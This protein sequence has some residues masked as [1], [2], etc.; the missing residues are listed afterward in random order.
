MRLSP[1]GTYQLEVG[2]RKS[3]MSLQIYLTLA[4]ARGLVCFILYL[5]ILLK[6]SPVNN[7]QKHMNIYDNYNFMYIILGG[8]NPTQ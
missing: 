1:P 6:N 5:Y 8:I 2:E 7:N 3:R 4:T